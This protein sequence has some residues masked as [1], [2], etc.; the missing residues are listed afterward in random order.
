MV[1]KFFRNLAEL[2]IVFISWITKPSAM[3]RDQ[4]S[5]E[6]AQKAIEGLSLYQLFACSYC[7]K[8]RRALHRFNVSVDI[9]D[10][11]SNTQYRTELKQQG[12]KI[13]VPCLRIEEDGVVKS[14]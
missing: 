6:K 8:T 10:I 11:G 5:Q 1:L 4:E 14:I 3:V 13:Q 9:K 12:G 7:V 2:S